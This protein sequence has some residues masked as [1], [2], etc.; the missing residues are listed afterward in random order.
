MAEARKAREEG[1][2][3]LLDLRL[4]FKEENET[5]KFIETLRRSFDQIEFI[6]TLS[7]IHS[8]IYN[9]KILSKY[10]SFVNGATITHIDQ[11]LSFG[12]LFNAHNAYNEV[13]LMFYSTGA[14]VPDDIES[15]TAERLLAGMFQL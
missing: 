11:C 10:K 1:K 6:V 5:K 12:A 9:R 3:L 14:I 7:A 13:P 15:A 2:T 4:D 8:E